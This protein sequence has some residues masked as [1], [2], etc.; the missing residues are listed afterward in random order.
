M[1]AVEGLSASNL[2]GALR[3]VQILRTANLDATGARVLATYTA[4]AELATQLTGYPGRKGVVWITHGVPLH[5]MSPN[6][7]PVD[8]LPVL[9]KLAAMLGQAQIVLYPVDQTTR[10]NVSKSDTSADTLQ[11]FASITGGR[12]YPNGN[13]EKAIGGALSDNAASYLL[14]Y[15]SPDMKPD[16]KYHTIRV[17][18]TVRGFAFRPSRATSPPVS[19]RSA[20]LLPI[21]TSV[22][23]RESHAVS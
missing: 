5:G 8:Y 13:I 12:L 20:I 2:D 9:K 17:T 7:T 6:G 18:C 1:H 22:L 10:P 11:Q 14:A 16:G 23:G 3:S 21:R 19:R 15:Q 4:L